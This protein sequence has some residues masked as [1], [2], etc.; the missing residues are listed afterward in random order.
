MP[1][2]G[3]S[4]SVRLHSFET[5]KYHVTSW[6]ADRKRGFIRLLLDSLSGTGGL[7]SCC[8]YRV[9]DSHEKQSECLH[10]SSGVHRGLHFYVLVFHASGQDCGV[11]VWHPVVPILKDVQQRL[12]CFAGDV[13]SMIRSVENG[14]RLDRRYL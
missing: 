13:A 2:A 1:R 14:S 5:Q 10:K 11:L 8:Y 7:P 12:K 6:P 3:Q 4:I 9:F